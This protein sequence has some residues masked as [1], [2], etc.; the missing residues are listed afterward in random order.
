MNQ[1]HDLDLFL[2]WLKDKFPE[3]HEKYARNFT[4]SSSNP[5]HVGVTNGYRISDEE[6]QYIFGIARHWYDL[7]KN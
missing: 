3:V 4:I 6:F 1:A 2:P 7:R 5:D